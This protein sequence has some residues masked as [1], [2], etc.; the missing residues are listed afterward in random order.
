MNSWSS[1]TRLQQLRQFLLQILDRN[2]VALRHLLLRFDVGIRQQRAI[3]HQVLA[4]GQELVQR[5]IE[6]PDHH[7][8][9]IHRFEQA[10]EIGT[11]HGQKLLQRLAARFFVARQNHGLHERQTIFGE[12]HVLGAAEPDTLGAELARDLRIAWNIR[13][14]ADAELAAELIGPA[15]EL[16]DVVVAQIR[17][18]GLRMAEHKHRP[19]CRR[20]K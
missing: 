2:L 10:G 1:S 20:A 15:H 9:S 3:H 7:R 16:A 11:L 4:L 5:R 19:S 12:E 13:I 6:R 18:D 8:V 17:F 14:G